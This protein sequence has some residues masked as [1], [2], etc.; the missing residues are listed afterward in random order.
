MLK[1]GMWSVSTQESIINSMQVWFGHNHTHWKLFRLLKVNQ[2]HTIL[3]FGMRF[4]S[5]WMSITNQM[6]MS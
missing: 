2:K 5:N 3:E 4:P 1:I 6:C